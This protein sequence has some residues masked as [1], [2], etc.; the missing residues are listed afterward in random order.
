[1]AL[2]LKH[3][4]FLGSLF[5]PLVMM[6]DSLASPDENGLDVSATWISRTV[7]ALIEAVPQLALAVLEVEIDLFAHFLDELMVRRL[8]DTGRGLEGLARGQRRE[9]DMAM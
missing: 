3:S 8:M 9:S 5:V 7:L 1:M 2:G 6:T 4:P